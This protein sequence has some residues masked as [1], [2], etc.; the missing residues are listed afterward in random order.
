MRITNSI[1]LNGKNKTLYFIALGGLYTYEAEIVKN[2]DIGEVQVIKC[3]W[4]R[5]LDK[6]IKTLEDADTL[7]RTD[8]EVISSIKQL[9]LSYFRLYGYVQIQWLQDIKSDYLCNIDKSINFVLANNELKRY[10][11]I[12]NIT[13]AEL[14][15]QNYKKSITILNA[16][17]YE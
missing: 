9:L 10:I 12:M 4:S 8:T 15:L 2:E 16:I 11:P 5:L 14:F 1:V 13:T 3:L 17:H 6:S 7:E